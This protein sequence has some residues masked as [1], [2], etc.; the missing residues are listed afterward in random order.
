MTEVRPPLAARRALLTAGALWLAGCTTLPAPRPETPP[1]PTAVPQAP[2]RKPKIGLALGGGAARGFAH[3]G[4]IKMLEAQGIVPDYV[5]GTSAGAVVGALYAGGFDAFAMQKLA[6]Q[7]DETLFADWTL[8]GPGL[9]KGEALQSF[10]NK[11]LRQR[12]LERLKLPFGAVATDLNSGERVF[13]RTGDSGMAVR[14]SAAVPGIFQPVAINGR[15]YVDGGLTSPV[16][17]RAARE[18]G[19]D[20]VIAVD[21]SAIPDGQPVDSMSA[22][23][24][25]TTTIMGGVIGKSELAGAD[26]VIRPRLPYVKSW[27]FAARHEA[28]IE[29]ERAAL[30]AL[31]G[32]R[33]KLAL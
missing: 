32:I 19:A 18:M 21:I 8:R 7:L 14:A 29:G 17:V 22:I 3:I 25:Q 1:P 31:P 26:V 2:P 20:F 28:M 33:Q 30:A 23:L 13:F 5:V 24:W 10:V 11:H 16:P 12:P 9:L 6:I 27:D 15:L 4:V